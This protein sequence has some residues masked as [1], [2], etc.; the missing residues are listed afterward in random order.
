LRS[1]TYRPRRANAPDLHGPSPKNNFQVA[2]TDWIGASA[3]QIRSTRDGLVQ[4]A[5]AQLDLDVDSVRPFG[6][7]GRL[8]AGVARLGFHRRLGRLLGP[9]RLSQDRGAPGLVAET[10]ILTVKRL[11]RTCVYTV[12]QGHRPTRR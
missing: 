5:E 7:V 2:I 9:V 12:L 1:F 8:A 3:S 4:A 6:V 11:L 10:F